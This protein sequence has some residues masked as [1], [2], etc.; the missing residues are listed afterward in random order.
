MTVARALLGADAHV[1][2]TAN[3]LAHLAVV[4]RLPAAPSTCSVSGSCTPRRRRP[5]TR[6]PS[7]TTGSPGWPPRPTCRAWRSV[8]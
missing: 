3:T 1:G 7:A 6:R 8:G 4:E 2:L 5:T